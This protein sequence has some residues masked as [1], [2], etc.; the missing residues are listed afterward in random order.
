MASYF[1]Y[2]PE[3]EYVSRT[4]DRSSSDETIEYDNYKYVEEEGKV[5][6][7]KKIDEDQK[8]ITCHF[9]RRKK[10]DD[11]GIIPDV[12]SQLLTQRKA[13][14]KRLK[15]ETNDFKKGVLECLQLQYKLV[16]C[17]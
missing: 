3:M 12:V 1:S 11:M 2:F 8:K 7:T 15:N 6:I 10:G 16:A 13:T 9:L 17:I 5:T 4:N 14:K